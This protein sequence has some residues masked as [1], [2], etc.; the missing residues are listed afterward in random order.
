MAGACRWSLAD[1]QP[2]NELGVAIDVLLLQ[3][4]EQPAPLADELQE[5][6]AR[7]VILGVD[8]E[9]IR[10]VVDSLAENCHLHLGRASVGGV[11]FVRTDD[12]GLSLFRESHLLHLHARPSRRIVFAEPHQTAV[13]S[14]LLRPAKPKS[15]PR[16]VK[17]CKEPASPRRANARSRPVSSTTLQAT[18]AARSSAP[19]SSRS[20]ARIAPPCR[21]LARPSDVTTAAGRSGSRRSSGTTREPTSSTAASSASSVM[22]SST[23]NSPLRSRRSDSR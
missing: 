11:R 21:T 9:V 2:S 13:C 1:A 16:T 3:V 15:Y 4:V 23:P 22:A 5:A 6:A 20:T 10:E 17:G 7:V 12:V 8:L 14:G 18:G 19:A